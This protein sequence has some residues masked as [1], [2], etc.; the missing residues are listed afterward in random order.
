MPSRTHVYNAIDTERDYQRDRWVASCKEASIE[1]REDN[2]KAVGEWLQF[3]HGYYMQAVF[4]ASQVAGSPVMDCFRKLAA[5]CVACMEVH[6]GFTRDG[7]LLMGPL[8][9]D[10]VYWMIDGEREYQ[11]KLGDDRTDGR[12]HT[13]LCYLCMFHTYLNRAIDGW[14]ENPG[15]DVALD[16]IRKLAGI[17]VHAMEDHGAPIRPKFDG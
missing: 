11:D 17:A 6:G 5:L 4:T 13:P 10:A 16:N 7:K 8:E 9:R 12:N 1:Y 15:D 14:T 2:T 3:I